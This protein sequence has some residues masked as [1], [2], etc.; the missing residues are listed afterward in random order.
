MKKYP[1]TESLKNL[2]HQVRQKANFVGLDENND[3]IFKEAIQPIIEFV[4]TIKLHGSNG[5]I[6]FTNQ[7]NNNGEVIG[8]TISFQSRNRVLSLTSDNAGFM[9]AYYGKDLSKLLEGITFN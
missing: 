3:P 1:S 5:G 6:I 8:Q 2:S 9:T 4:G 7:H